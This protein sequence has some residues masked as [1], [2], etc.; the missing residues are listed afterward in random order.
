MHLLQLGI[1]PPAIDVAFGLVD[2]PEPAPLASSEVRGI[3]TKSAERLDPGTCDERD[4][5]GMLRCPDVQTHLLP[6]PALALVDRGGKCE[7]QRK[8]GA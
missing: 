5:Q 2:F 4:A 8:L 6:C 3:E 7:A 1:Y